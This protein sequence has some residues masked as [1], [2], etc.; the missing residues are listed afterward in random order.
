MD[1]VRMSSDVQSVV[2]L[3]FYQTRPAPGRLNAP[4]L[5]CDT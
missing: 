1:R 3:A 5:L 2:V 4:C